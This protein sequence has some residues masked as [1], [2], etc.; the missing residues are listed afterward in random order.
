[1]CRIQEGR[2]SFIYPYNTKIKQIDG[3]CLLG[4][5]DTAKIQH[6]VVS[7]DHVSDRGFSLREFNSLC[8]MEVEILVGD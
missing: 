8:Q 6:V 1:M 3:F 2:F 4:R 5:L 7:D